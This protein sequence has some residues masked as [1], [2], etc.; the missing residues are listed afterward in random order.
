MGTAA[1]HEEINP[2]EQ[3][4]ED[5]ECNFWQK[6]KHGKCTKFTRI[7]SPTLESNEQQP[8]L[9]VYGRR[10][11]RLPSVQPAT[12]CVNLTDATLFLNDF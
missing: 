6:L 9:K 3:S 12:E 2:V 1:S 10:P 5:N 4:T 8:L 7:L 11:F